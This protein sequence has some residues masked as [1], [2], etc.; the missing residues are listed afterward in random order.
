MTGN[1]YMAPTG[2]RMEI[3]GGGGYKLFTIFLIYID[4]K[5]RKLGKVKI[6]NQNQLLFNVQTFQRIIA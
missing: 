5:L 4:I 3:L 2:D 1:Y 6:I